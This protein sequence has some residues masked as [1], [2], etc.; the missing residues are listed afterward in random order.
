[1][2]AKSKTIK[3]KSKKKDKFLPGKF[4]VHPHHGAAKVIRK[5]NKN[6]SIF[7]D[8]EPRSKRMEYYEIEIL[9]D[10]LTVHVPIEKVNDVIRPVISKNAITTKVMPI[11][12]EKPEEA[13]TNWS[14]W[15]KVLTEKMTSGD[16]LQVTEVVRDLTHAQINKG[17]SPA[18][19]RMLAKA[20]TT[21]ASELACTLGIDEEAA[22]EKIDQNLPEA[23]FDDGL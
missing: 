10:G 18:L 13:G 2:A 5:V 20:R 8:G 15:Y 6:V 11:F 9:T 4:V 14:R 21:L 1:M 17:I 3:A 23:A 19:K 16:V 7:V 22:M 12:K